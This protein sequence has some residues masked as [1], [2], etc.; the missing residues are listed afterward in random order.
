[1]GQWESTGT[2]YCN[3]T[4]LFQ[5]FIAV[6]ELLWRRLM[7]THIFL[8]YDP[9]LQIEIFHTCFQLKLKISSPSNLSY[10][11]NTPHVTC[12]MWHVKYECE[13][14]CEYEYHHHTIFGIGKLKIKEKKCKNDKTIT[15]HVGKRSLN[16]MYIDIEYS[17]APMPGRI[18]QLVSEHRN[19]LKCITYTQCTANGFPKSSIVHSSNIE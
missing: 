1:M 9:H 2:L 15:V 14:E 17:N 8:S 16:Y 10:L 19:R 4:S 3:R 12:D 7:V 11:Y 18:S 6:T 5:T 13:C